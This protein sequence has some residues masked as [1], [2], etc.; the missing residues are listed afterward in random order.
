MGTITIWLHDSHLPMHFSHFFT[1]EFFLYFFVKVLLFLASILFLFQLREDLLQLLLVRSL[2][3]LLKEDLSFL[4]LGRMDIFIFPSFL[5]N[6]WM[7]MIFMASIVF[8]PSFHHFENAPLHPFPGL[9][10]FCQKFPTN[11]YGTFLVRDES[12]LYLVAFK[13]ISVT[14]TALVI[15][16]LGVGLFVSILFWSPLTFWK[17]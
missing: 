16:C 12:L 3:V 17:F 6:C 2:M 1:R 11:L 4:Y 5:R 7:D 13:I 14:L 9:W 15:M 8:F 10:H